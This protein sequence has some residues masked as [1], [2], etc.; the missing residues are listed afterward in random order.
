MWDYT[1]CDEK[2]NTIIMNKI[3]TNKYYIPFKTSTNQGVC[4]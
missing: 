2:G 4:Y 3:I 1:E